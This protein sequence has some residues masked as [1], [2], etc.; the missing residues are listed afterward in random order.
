MLSQ[1]E[2]AL[3]FKYK[4]DNLSWAIIAEK[5][6]KPLTTVKSFY[7]RN[8]SRNGLETEVKKRNLKTDGCIGLQIKNIVK[9]NLSISIR[10][11]SQQLK[12]NCTAC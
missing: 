3:I 2:K 12:A 1:E 6:N 5:L 8:K 7:F 10:N 4:K 9:C 11:L